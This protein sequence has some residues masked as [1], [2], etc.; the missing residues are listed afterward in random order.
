MTDARS[1]RREPAEPVA[2]NGL[3]RRQNT[4]LVVLLLVGSLL[5]ALP[6][7]DVGIDGTAAVV[8]TGLGAV[9]VCALYLLGARYVAARARAGRG[10]AWWTWLG[11]RPRTRAEWVNTIVGLLVV[12]AGLLA[13]WVVLFRG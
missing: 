9:L 11:P 6:F 8:L 4:T 2:G 1:G 13:G 10:G 7:A 5:I 3:T 12:A